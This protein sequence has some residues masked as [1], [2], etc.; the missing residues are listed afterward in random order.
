MLNHFLMLLLPPDKSKAMAIKCYKEIKNTAP[1]NE[2]HNIPINSRPAA[3][4]P[5]WNGQVYYWLTFGILAFKLTQ[6]NAWHN[7]FGSE[8]NPLIF[9]IIFKTV[10]AFTKQIWKHVVAKF[11]LYLFLEFEFESFII[12]PL[13]AS[14][15]GS[16]FKS[17]TKKF[18]PPVFLG[19][20]NS[21]TLSLC[22]E[23]YMG[24][25][26]SLEFDLTFGEV[27]VVYMCI[28][29]E[30]MHSNFALPGWRHECILI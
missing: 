30:S 10:V 12:I 21:V 3:L 13:R 20:C 11:I 24:E 9:Q 15:W 19:V 4:K 25:Q 5:V 1:P 29:F 6:K 7:K 23:G 22:T 16:L 27:L 26:P 18:H 14:E 28:I 17:G 8:S 2:W